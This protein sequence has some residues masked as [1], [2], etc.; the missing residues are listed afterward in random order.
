[1]DV[2]A[3]AWLVSPHERIVGNRKACLSAIRSSVCHASMRPDLLVIGD[4]ARVSD[5]R[6]VVSTRSELWGR[7]PSHIRRFMW[8]SVLLAVHFWRCVLPSQARN[9]TGRPR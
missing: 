7:V 3:V 4:V 6:S 8:M 5:V 2:E 9:T 1:M